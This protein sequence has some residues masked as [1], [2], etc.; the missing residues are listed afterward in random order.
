MQPPRQVAVI[1]AGIIGV[2]CALE[3]LKSGHRVTIIEPSE[4]GAAQAASYGNGAWLSPSSVVPMSM[5][6][7]W[8]KIPGY[9]SDP[10]SPLTIRWR[11]LPSLAPWLIRFL[12]AGATV[13]KVQY[14]AH[15]LSQLLGDAPQ[16]HLAL[17]ASIG[18]P[19]LVVQ[20]GLLYPYPCRKD[21]EAES[22]AWRLRRDNGIKWN[23]VEAQALR[24]LAP[25]L[26]AR[27]G[28]GIVVGSGGN[29]TNPGAYVGAI[30]QHCEQLGA[31]RIQAKA[32]GFEIS[33]GPG[34]ARLVGVQSSIGLVACDQAVLAAGI[35]SKSLA[36]SLGD[37]IFLESERGYHVVFENPGIHVSPPLMPGDAKMAIT[38]T[39]TG[40]RVS[41]QVELASVEAP[42]DWRRAE[43]L[44]CFA[45]EHFPALQSNPQHL[46]AIDLPGPA[47][48]G[49][50]RWMGHRPSTPD[51]LPILGP[52]AVCPDVFYAFGHG[53]VGLA[54]GPIS[55]C[56][57]ADLVSQRSSS[58][59]LAPY[60]VKRFA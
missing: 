6:G 54:S 30:A 15:A 51:G 24:R 7:L 53:H 48:I 43:L 13:S 59:N 5:P 52:S 40:F 10:A 14:T 47:P 56:I 35:G 11:A 37:R 33:S 55:G 17:A 22:L 36:Q 46:Q 25:Y 27:Y 18:R 39:Q 19:E 12:K 57:I 16:R 45:L 21:F 42:P 29:A 32:H 34:Q 23:E 60:S 49:L 4:P 2:C 58:L 26:G 9:L 38:S 3:L 1:G 20:E 31:T 41:G 8:K 44:R 50:K 28:F